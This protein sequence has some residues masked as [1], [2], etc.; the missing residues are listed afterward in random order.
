MS[1][2]GGMRPAD[3]A[4]Y[5]MPEPGWFV[6]EGWSLTPE[7]AGMARLMGRGPHLGPIAAFVRRRPEAVTLVVGGRNLGAAEDGVAT[8]AVTVDGRPVDHWQAPPGFFVRTLALPAGSLS[9]QGRWS[10]V[11][12]ASTGGE[13]RSIATAIEQF[14][15]Q[16]P[17][18]LMWAFGEG[19][20]EPELDNL[21]A[22]S[23]RWMS[24]HAVIEVPQGSGDATL[25]LR[26]ESPLTYFA[27]PSTLEVRSGEALLGRVELSGDFEV[28]I[29]VLASRLEAGRTLRLT[30]TQ[31]FSPAEGG[32]SRDARRLGLRFFAVE[33][34]P[35]LPSR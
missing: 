22:R 32:R 20:H 18:V 8:F 16:S 4:W 15:V 29:G 5:R 19:F 21:R 13:G 17:G 28:R 12:I 11:G 30:T 10:T 34:T 2:L 3:V 23:W 24:D 35:G 9:G 27:K 31:T 25:V 14:D 33:L 1:Q 26:G 6:T 7:T